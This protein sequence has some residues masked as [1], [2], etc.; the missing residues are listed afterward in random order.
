MRTENEADKAI[1]GIKRTHS[2]LFW[3][4][5]NALGSAENSHMHSSQYGRFMY[6]HCLVWATVD[7]K[8]FF[9]IKEME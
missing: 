7:Y 1:D 8:A 9:Y 3:R 2:L 4:N 5:A 6:D